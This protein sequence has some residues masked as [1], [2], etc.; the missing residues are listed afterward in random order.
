MEKLREFIHEKGI[1]YVLV[2]DYYLPMLG[3]AEEKRPIGHWGGCT[4]N[5]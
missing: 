5:I 1:D 4:R 2:G 3:L